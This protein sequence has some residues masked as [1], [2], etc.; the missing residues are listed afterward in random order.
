M[1]PDEFTLWVWAGSAIL[2]AWGYGLFDGP[3]DWR[4]GR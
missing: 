4:K 3:P 2:I 1:T